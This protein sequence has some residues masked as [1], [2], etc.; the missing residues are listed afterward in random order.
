MADWLIA[1]IVISS[2]LGAALIVAAGAGARCGCGC[3]CQVLGVC[4]YYLKHLISR[5]VKS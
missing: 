3:Q 5:K 1:V 2:L 4:W